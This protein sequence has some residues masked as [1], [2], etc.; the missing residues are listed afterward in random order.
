MLVAHMNSNNGR[1]QSAELVPP[2]VPLHDIVPRANGSLT[3]LVSH[4]DHMQACLDMCHHDCYA[5]I[6]AMQIAGL[7]TSMLPCTAVA[8]A[9]HKHHHAIYSG[10]NGLSNRR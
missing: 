10:V 3:F 1:L 6:D 7:Y 4:A 5:L 2:D 8:G 9:K